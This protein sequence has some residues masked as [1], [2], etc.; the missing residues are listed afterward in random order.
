MHA[1]SVLMTD[2]C[3]TIRS[4]SRWQKRFFVLGEGRLD[5]YSTMPSAG[6]WGY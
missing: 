1:C 6:E 5:Y 2:D 3:H 4:L